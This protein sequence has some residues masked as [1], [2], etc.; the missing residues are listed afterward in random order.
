[1]SHHTHTNESYSYVFVSRHDT[2][3]TGWRRRVRCL[4]VIGHFPQKSPIISGSFAEN[5]L[6]L[7]ASYASSPLCVIR[8]N[9][10]TSRMSVAHTNTFSHEPISLQDVAHAGKHTNVQHVQGGEDS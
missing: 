10:S 5:D 1:M 9:T 6:H 4:I 3:Y 2:S 7:K 8:T